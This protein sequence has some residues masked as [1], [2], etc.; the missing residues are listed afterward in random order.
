M[1]T[2]VVSGGSLKRQPSRLEQKGSDNVQE[3]NRL[4]PSHG[5]AHG[6]ASALITVKQA[7]A[8]GAGSGRKIRLMC[9]RGELKAAKVGSD[10]RLARDPFL[11]HFGLLD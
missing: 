7:E 5:D 10:W 8:I 4:Q 2:P 11:R 6:G 3:G 9:A 1:V